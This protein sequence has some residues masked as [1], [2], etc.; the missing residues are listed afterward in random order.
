MLP[1]PYTEDDGRVAVSERLQAHHRLATGQ[2][3]QS[4][5]RGRGSGNESTA[6]PEA[7]SYGRSMPR[8]IIGSP[9]FNHA[10]DFRE[11]IES[12]LGQT[13]TDFA[14]VLVDDC[15]TDETPAIAREYA[16]LDAA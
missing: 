7:T 10:K 8:V 2:R 5:V 12:I 9:L 13:F 4:T 6:M 11:A 14:L 1:V 16:A 15:S 3:S